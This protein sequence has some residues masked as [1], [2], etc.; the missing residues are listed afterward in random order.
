MVDTNRLQGGP[1]TTTLE[2]EQQQR[3]KLLQKVRKLWFLG[4]QCPLTAEA[5][6][7]GAAGARAPNFD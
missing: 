6:E 5:R 2:L 1:E 3:L 7:E 4:A